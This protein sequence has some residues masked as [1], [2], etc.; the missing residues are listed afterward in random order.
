MKNYT[1]IIENLPKKF[2][3]QLYYFHMALI[4]LRFVGKRKIMEITKFHFIPNCL[5]VFH[6]KVDQN[7]LNAKMSDNG[8]VG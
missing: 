1:I 6:V 7:M 8:N 5:I 3:P 2:L 4:C